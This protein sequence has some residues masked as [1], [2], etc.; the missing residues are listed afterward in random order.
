MSTGVWLGGVGT[1][2]YTTGYGQQAGG[3]HPTGMLSRRD[4]FFTIHSLPLGLC[5]TRSAKTST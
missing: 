5:P 1:P 4:L 2:P 3:M